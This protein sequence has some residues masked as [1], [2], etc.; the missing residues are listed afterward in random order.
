[1]D[2]TADDRFILAACD[3]IWDC[4]SNQEA[5]DKMAGKF[6]MSMPKSTEF[7]VPVGEMLDEILAKDTETGIGTDNMTAI[8]IHFP[9]S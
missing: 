9:D 7:H 5:A 2:R 4:L 8:V 6:K 3:G 1:V